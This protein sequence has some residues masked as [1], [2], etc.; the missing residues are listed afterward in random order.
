L[1]FKLDHYRKSRELDSAGCQRISTST[2]TT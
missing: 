1:D 2:D